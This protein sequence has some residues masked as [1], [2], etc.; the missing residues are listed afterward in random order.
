MRLRR[1]LLASATM[2]ALIS[3]AGFSPL[4]AQP[5]PEALQATAVS[6]T[7]IALNWTPVGNPNVVGYVIYRADGTRIETVPA[8]QN[9]YTDR[10]L[11]PWTVYSYYVTSSFG[12]KESAASN[13]ASARTLDGSP[14]T[15][16]GNLQGSA[17]GSARISLTW[18]AAS[19]PES[20]IARYVVYRNG[21]AIAQTTS[22]GYT[23]EGLTP[24]TQ[25]GYEVS[26]VNNANDEGSRAGPI[27]VR[28][29]GEPPP[30]P[31]RNLSASAVSATAIDLSWSPPA[32][33]SGVA[34]YRVYR[35]G[36]LVASPTGTTYRD[37]GLTSYTQYQYYVTAVN[38]GGD[39]SGPS[40]TVSQRTLDGSPPTAPGNLQGSAASSTRISLSWTAASDPQTGIDQYV[41]YRGGSEIGRTST[42]S[43]ID[44][45]LT[46]DTPYS[47]EVSAVNGQDIEGGKAGPIQVRT[48][49]DPTPGAPRNLSATA[50][51]ASV[52]DLSWNP[53][54]DA[55]GVTG[56]RVYR[57]GSRI[58]APTGTS[59]RDS[60]LASYTTYQYYVTAVGPGGDESEASNT[61]SVRTLDG[62]P[63]TAPGNLQGSA[64]S[65]SRISL[66]WTAASD[67]QTGIAGY[68]VYRDG[69][70]IDRTSATGYEDGGLEADQVYSYQVAAVNGQ[71]DEGSPAGP[72]QVRTPSN[73]P[74]DPP[75]GLDAVAVDDSTVDLTWDQHP[76]EADLDGYRVY[77]NGSL[78][79]GT[80]TSQYRDE[81]LDPFTTYT[82]TVTAVSEDGDESAA[83]DP[84]SVT[85]PDF[86]PPTPP[87]SIVAAAVGGTRIDVSW[88]PAVD[89]Q[90]GISG[91][92]VFRDG[93][94]VAVTEATAYQDGELTPGTTYEY[95]VSAINGAGV[96]G[97]PSGPASATTPDGTG[98]TVPTGLTAT[99]VSTES[100]SLSW[101]AS[102][103][104]ESGIAY[105][106]VFRAG[107]EIA[108]PTD[109]EYLDVGLQAGTAYEY[110]VSAVNGDGLES[111]LSDP[112]TATTEEPEGPPPPTDLTATPDGPNRIT[113][114]WVAPAGGA[115]SY[116]VYRDGSFVGSVTS[117]AFIDTGLQPGTTYGYTVASVDSE[118]VAGTKSAEVSAT[119]PGEVDNVPPAP[120]TGLR[121]V[122]P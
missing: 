4:Q 114:A 94:E 80:T 62:S 17:V 104:A 116:N 58:A 35:S 19:D 49:A 88:S 42:L 44:D 26:A 46:P 105:Y 91:Y 23:D 90:S 43:F 101:N 103:D 79:T 24:D 29:L 81:G 71:G 57:N 63:P 47:Y 77:R 83:S 85:T 97:E 28:T 9:T 12:D 51:S 39:E 53:P 11:Q 14:P 121:V 8:S 20:G 21:S 113:V 87:G 40:N 76:D 31:P 3:V 86:T 45:G 89:E 118:G 55:S 109:T 30:D 108:T 70:E 67:P 13:V 15:A 82:Y 75:T 115:A 64:V 99:G 56:Y 61:V 41:I 32:D 84:A 69:S 36:S 60:G 33:P 93:S 95:R 48:L 111:D 5:T 78:L 22:T 112:A 1:P 96:E 7:E 54:A 117:T 37:T 68:V 92:R 102:T 66:S 38:A 18:T 72:I 106:R 10:G 74:P 52:I 120:P 65:Q 73:P 16:P 122:N 107:E 6:S 59:Y 110:R 34:G 25:Y 98:P 100:I 50:V 2:A 27:Q 119:T